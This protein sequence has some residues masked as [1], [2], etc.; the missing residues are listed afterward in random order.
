[1]TARADRAAVRDVAVAALAA[2]VP[3]VAGRI[4]RSR[5]WP[6]SVAN[7]ASATELPA[8]LV[9]A[10]PETKTRAHARASVDKVYAVRCDL[11]VIARVAA[12][13]GPGT[14]EMRLESALEELAGAVEAAILESG[15]LFGGMGAVEDCEEVR[16]E[17][18]VDA[19]G[20]T[21]SGSAVLV[22]SLSWSEAWS[23][24]M[25]E[26]CDDPTIAL[27]AVPSPGILGEDGAPLT[28]ATGS[29]ITP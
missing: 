7:G 1:M 8:L 15:A 4:Y 18:S 5:V 2:G 27:A 22:F 20:G 25:P 19:E 17:L 9:F 21:L 14:P 26:T 10:S 12:P 29:Y 13:P 23:V 28:D 11:V 24:P 3:Q 6:I 16:T